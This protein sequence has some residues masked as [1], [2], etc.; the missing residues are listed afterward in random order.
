MGV[1]VCWCVGVL[2]CWHVG[3]LACWRVLVGMVYLYG[4]YG[5]Y[6][7]IENCSHL[8]GILRIIIM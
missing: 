5:L 2:A 4:L 1:L 3:V 7:Y 8:T 6:W